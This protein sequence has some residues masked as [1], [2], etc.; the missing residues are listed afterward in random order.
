M[1]RVIYLRRPLRGQ[2]TR[3]LQQQLERVFQSQWGQTKP[4]IRVAQNQ[5]VWRP[6]A[7]VYET[8]SAFVVCVEVAGMRDAEI[9]IM[10]D[11]R[12]LHIEGYRSERRIEQLLCYDQIGV[13]YGAFE[14]E[15]FLPRPVDYERVSARYDDGFL[16]VELPKPTQNTPAARVHVQVAEE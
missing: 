13:N 9:A 4:V 5:E 1:Q 8:E 10:L 7:D 11:E 16:F 14:L 6:P 15:V 2:N 3:G 12:S